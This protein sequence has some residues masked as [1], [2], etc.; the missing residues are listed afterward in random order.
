MTHGLSG[1]SLVS[2]FNLP[3]LTPK[4]HHCYGKH[5]NTNEQNSWGEH[6]NNNLI[7]IEKFLIIRSSCINLKLYSQEINYT[8]RLER[9]LLACQLQHQ[10][11]L[12]RNIDLGGNQSVMINEII[13]NLIDC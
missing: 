3:N 1:P 5:W 2:F 11:S 10:T 12:L 9:I 7:S 8:H 13:Y 4:Y 6:F